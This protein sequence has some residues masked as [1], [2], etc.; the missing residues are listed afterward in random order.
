[1]ASYTNAIM[2]LLLVAGVALLGTAVLKFGEP[3]AIAATGNALGNTPEN[4]QSLAAKELPDKC[5]VPPG[6]DPVKWKEHLGHH[7]DQYAECL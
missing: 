6:Q 4:F 2:A 5:A 7:P 1:M 3:P